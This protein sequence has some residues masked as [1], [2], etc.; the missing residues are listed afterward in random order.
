[1]TFF[2]CT[3]FV[4]ALALAQTQRAVFDVL[5][6]DCLRW[7]AK[8]SRLYEN[9]RYWGDQNIANLTAC[10]DS[11][12]SCGAQARAQTVRMFRLG[13]TRYSDFR[14]EIVIVQKS[15]ARLEFI[16]ETALKWRYKSL[17]T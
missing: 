14:F 10:S 5:V 9:N 12:P 7:L 17:I 2:S 8:Y 3:Q 1:M 6:V 4:L 15:Y 11:V 16:L 13:L